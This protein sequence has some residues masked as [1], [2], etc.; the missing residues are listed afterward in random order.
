MECEKFHQQL[1]EPRKSIYYLSV[2]L[3][4]TSFSPVASLRFRSVSALVCSLRCPGSTNTSV[5]LPTF[6][7]SV[8]R[9]MET[10]NFAA[11]KPTTKYHTYAFMCLGNFQPTVQQYGCTTIVGKFVFI[12]GGQIHQ[13]RNPPCHLQRYNNTTKVVGKFRFIRRANLSHEEIRH[14]FACF[15]AVH[16]AVKGMYD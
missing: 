12:F 7:Q 6:E 5:S 9:K 2:C 3:E 10:V 4:G 11:N 14:F 8:H 1:G 13:R 15:T 16:Y